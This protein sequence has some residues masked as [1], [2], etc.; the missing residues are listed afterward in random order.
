MRENPKRNFILQQGLGEPDQPTCGRQYSALIF[1]GRVVLVWVVAGSLLRISPIFFALSAALWWSAL[2]PKLNPFDA[3]HNS[4][5]GGRAGAFHLTPAPAPR[6]FAQM[7]AGTFALAC[8]LLLHSG[9]STA[10]YVWK[11]FFWLPSWHS[12][13]EGSARALSYTT[14]CAETWRSPFRP[15][16]GR[17]PNSGAKRRR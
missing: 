6:R 7:M 9:H 11:G 1:Q 15:C 12:R 17:T 13:W 8:G 16:L 3:V 2:L 5:F 4:L 10:A 14:C